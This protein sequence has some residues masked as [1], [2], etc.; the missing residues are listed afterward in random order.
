MSNKLTPEE[1]KQLI[2]VLDCALQSDA[3]TVISALQNLVLVASLA[4]E[5][6][7]GAGPLQSMFNRVN[8]L[9]RDVDR[10]MHEAEQTKRY[11]ESTERENHNRKKHNPYDTYIGGTTPT[12]AFYDEWPAKYSDY[13]DLLKGKK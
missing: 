13:K 3:P 10:L 6:K 4:A 12:R 11:M 9:Q 8:S 2:G 5:F 7:S 1:V